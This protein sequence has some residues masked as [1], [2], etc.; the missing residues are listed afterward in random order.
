MLFS[1]ALRTNKKKNIHVDET[2]KKVYVVWVRL[3]SNKY[4]DDLCIY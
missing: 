2:E 4:Q 1:R 3:L